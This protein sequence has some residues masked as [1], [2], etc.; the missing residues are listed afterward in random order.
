[1]CLGTL[2]RVCIHIGVVRALSCTVHC[3]VSDGRL[4]PPAAPAPRLTRP[5]PTA[6][7][8][9]G[10]LSDALHLLFLARSARAVTRRR[11]QRT[12][13]RRRT[14]SCSG[15]R[16]KSASQKSRSCRRVQGTTLSPP[17]P[18]HPAPAPIR[19]TP[20][21]PHNTTRHTPTPAGGARGAEA[22]EGCGGGAAG[23]G[24]ALG[25]RRPRGGVAAA[26]GPRGRPRRPRSREVRSPETRGYRRRLSPSPTPATQWFRWR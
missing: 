24:A 20:P 22:R 1:M 23:G 2:L 9:S 4:L 7:G 26:G 13:R 19:T 14:S 18:P 10:P 15:S 3:S 17:H 5:G 12:S 8:V 16:R 21:R 25:V 6:M 11:A